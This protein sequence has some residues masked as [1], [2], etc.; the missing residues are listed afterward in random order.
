MPILPST[1]D[2]EIV[3]INGWR[4]EI[5]RVQSVEKEMKYLLSKLCM[6]YEQKQGK[7]SM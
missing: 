3:Q 5:A 7:A 1:A 4:Q 2:K 6:L